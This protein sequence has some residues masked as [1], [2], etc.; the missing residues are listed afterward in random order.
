MVSTDCLVAVSSGN[1]GGGVLQLTS[2]CVSSAPDQQFVVSAAPV[3]SEI[4]APSESEYGGN[5]APIAWWV[6]HLWGFK[7]ITYICIPLTHTRN[8]RVV[9]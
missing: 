2:A 6:M 4:P 3:A 9:P 1:V 7:S 8:P 5:S